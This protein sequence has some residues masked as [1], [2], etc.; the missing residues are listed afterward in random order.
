[1]KKLLTEFLFLFKSCICW[2]WYLHF[3]HLS[4]WKTKVFQSR[5]AGVHIMPTQLKNHCTNPWV[6]QANWIQS[7]WCFARTPR[8]NGLWHKLQS[9]NNSVSAESSQKVW[10]WVIKLL[11]ERSCQWQNDSNCQNVP[12]EIKI[13][14]DLPFRIFHKK[15]TQFNIEKMPQL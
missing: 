4:L 7:Y 12:A 14:D 6:S 2:Y 15:Q 13:F 1:M 3:C 5:R 11:C 9:G 8:T 10:I